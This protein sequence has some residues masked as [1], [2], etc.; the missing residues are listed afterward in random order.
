MAQV[1]GLFM[2]IRLI[3]LPLLVH[4]VNLMSLKQCQEILRSK[5][6]AQ[7]R[8][9]AAASQFMAGATFLPQNKCMNFLHQPQNESQRYMRYTWS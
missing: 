4:R 3:V 2:E 9:L 6:A 1:A 7:Q 5:A 8:K